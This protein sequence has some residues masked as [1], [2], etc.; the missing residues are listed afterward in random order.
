MLFY[1]GGSGQK[2]ELITDS[3][4][5]QQLLAVFTMKRHYGH[6]EVGTQKVLP[7]NLSLLQFGT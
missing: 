4:G 5:I 2:T 7:K 1:I 6:P 3:M